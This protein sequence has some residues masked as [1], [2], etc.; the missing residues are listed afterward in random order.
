M[1][2]KF[3]CSACGK[4]L[5][6]Q[7]ENAGRRSKCPVCGHEIQVPLLTGLE[8]H[9]PS[10]PIPPSLPPAGM[11]FTDDGE[12]ADA[13]RGRPFWKDPIVV[14]GAAV[15]TLV[16]SVFFTYLAW[17]HIRAIR[18]GAAVRNVAGRE[19]PSQQAAP[20][21]PLPAKPRLL[22][23]KVEQPKAPAPP[24]KKDTIDKAPSEDPHSSLLLG[25]EAPVPKA[26]ES[27]RL[28]TGQEAIA[29]TNQKDSEDCVAIYVPSLDAEG[30]YAAVLRPDFDPHKFPQLKAGDR[31]I[32]I[33]DTGDESRST[34]QVRVKV[35]N[36]Q[37]AGRVGDMAR[38]DVRPKPR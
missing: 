35:E 9:I 7:D 33:E 28:A 5:S 21:E 20:T 27:S 16:L 15:P 11:Q 10:E 36:G 8:P 37:L 2:I 3:S 23:A 6:V 12:P 32:I 17:P 14:I 29:Y 1:A 34:R 22:A 4:R 31:L 13:E 30:A 18:G 26:A 25:D 19:A 24:P 38:K